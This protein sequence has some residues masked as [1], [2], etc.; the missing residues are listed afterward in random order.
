M[1]EED[2]KL[3]KALPP[4]TTRLAIVSVVFLFLSIPGKFILGDSCILYRKIN[5]YIFLVTSMLAIAL[6]IFAI[7]SVNKSKGKLKGER[8]GCTVVAI[9]LFLLFFMLVMLPRARCIAYRT[10]CGMNLWRLSEAILV[11]VNDND[12]KFPSAADWCDLLIENTDVNEEDFKCKDSFLPVFSYGFNI[13]L[14]GLRLAEVPPDVVL[15]FEIKGG[16]NVSGGPELMVDNKHD[17]SGSNIL[18]TDF[19]VIFASKVHRKGLKW[20]VPKNMKSSDYNVLVE[21]TI[22]LIQAG[23]LE[24]PPSLVSSYAIRDVSRYPLI[25]AGK[26]ALPAIRKKFH[27]HIDPDVKAYFLLSMFNI[28]QAEVNADALDVLKNE[29]DEELCWVA[30]NGLLA[31][32]TKDIL[33]ELASLLEQG[34]PNGRYILAAAEGIAQVMLPHDQWVDLSEEQQLNKRKHYFLSWWMKESLKTESGS[35]P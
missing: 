31:Y 27:E 30:S 24:Y 10:Q 12:G 21:E 5:T 7:S 20:E 26:S 35:T 11:Y 17:D 15:L 32:G 23:Q 25:E 2:T 13:H 29:C 33:P 22:K 14:D 3:K 16:R 9:G 34:H 4:K 19:N 18:L 6:A 28:A 1:T 8:L